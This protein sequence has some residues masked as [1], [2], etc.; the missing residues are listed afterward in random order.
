MEKSSTEADPESIHLA[1]GH[2]D[3]ED[4]NDMWNTLSKSS[5]ID[6]DGYT[7]DNKFTENVALYYEEAVKRKNIVS[8]YF[9]TLFQYRYKTCKKKM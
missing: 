5:H 1:K 3:L 6:E 7:L 9:N 4:A 8:W 2:S